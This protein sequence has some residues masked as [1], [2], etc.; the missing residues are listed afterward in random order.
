MAEKAATNEIVFDRRQWLAGTNAKFL[1]N[2]KKSRYVS[3]AK[4]VSRRLASR[5]MYS[6]SYLVILDDYKEVKTL[7]KPRDKKII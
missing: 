4:N 2:F 1:A 5:E 3:S 6:F 7:R